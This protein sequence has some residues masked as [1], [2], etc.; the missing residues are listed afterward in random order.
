MSIA[1]VYDKDV[2]GRVLSREELDKHIVTWGTPEEVGEFLVQQDPADFLVDY[3]SEM[4]WV[5]I[6]INRARV[7]STTGLEN[8]LPYNTIMPFDVL[9]LDM[10]GPFSSKVDAEECATAF[11]ED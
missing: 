8:V 7:Y 4:Y 5:I 1:I 9:I 2:K 6:P 3:M 10:V 11:N